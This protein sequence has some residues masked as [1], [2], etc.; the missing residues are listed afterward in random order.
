M[1]D[2]GPASR[3]GAGLAPLTSRHPQV[4]V[5][6]FS[7]QL[8]PDGKLHF[9]FIYEFFQPSVTGGQENPWSKLPPHLNKQQ[10]HDKILSCALQLHLFTYPTEQKHGALLNEGCG[11]RAPGAGIP[12]ANLLAVSTARAHWEHIN[13]LCTEPPA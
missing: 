8:I 1:G 12:H 3:D 9:A 2:P 7:W 10:N 13:A 5:K 6:V 11:C 4:P